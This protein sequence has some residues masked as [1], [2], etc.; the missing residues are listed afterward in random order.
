M[1]DA[2]RRSLIPWPA[3]PPGVAALAICQLVLLAG[4]L[5]LEPTSGRGIKPGAALTI[6]TALV[7]CAFIPHL[8]AWTNP[9]T[10]QELA[11]GVACGAIIGA[12]L[13]CRAVLRRLS[14]RLSPTGRAAG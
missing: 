9:A 10:G 12:W 13:G 6:V 4:F 8:L 3:I 14:Q 1:V 11:A 2:T 7:L 5:A